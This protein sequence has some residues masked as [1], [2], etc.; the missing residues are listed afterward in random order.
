MGRRVVGFIFALALGLMSVAVAAAPAEAATGVT[1]NTITAAAVPPGGKVKVAPKI[2][3]VGEVE[4]TKKYFTI[5][6]SSGEKIVSKKTS[7][8]LS[9]GRYQVKTTV[10]WKAKKRSGG[11]Y[12]STTTTRIQTLKVAV[13]TANCATVADAKRVNTGDSAK[14][15]SWKLFS[16][17]TLDYVDGSHE[18]WRYTL[19]DSTTQWV[20][21]SYT[22]GKVTDI[23]VE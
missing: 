6:K 9:A 8:W 2:S 3:T 15:V 17:G 19:C 14:V 12:P 21:V 1:I 20:W 23:W 4:V 11:Y 10:T 5:W 22:T 16:A 13:N 7:A 18:H